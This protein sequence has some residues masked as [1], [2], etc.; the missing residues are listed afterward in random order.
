MLIT[1]RSER[2]SRRRPGRRLAASLLVVLGTVFVMF[3]MAW[4]VGVRP[5]PLGTD[6]DPGDATPWARDLLVTAGGPIG[7]AL[8]LFGALQILAGV[9]LTRQ[10][11][12]SRPLAFAAAFG[13]ILIGIGIVIVAALDAG[14]ADPKLTGALA[15][16]LLAGLY[17]V[18]LAGARTVAPRSTP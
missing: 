13:G 14:P 2:A 4:L 9:V 8:A 17:A 7:V 15:G 1:I 11:R 16:L 3:A 6:S 10:A 5:G 18:I 12:W